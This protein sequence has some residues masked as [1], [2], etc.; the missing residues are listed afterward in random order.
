MLRPK[1]RGLFREKPDMS[2]MLESHELQ[3]RIL[4]E[5]RIIEHLKRNK[6]VVLGLN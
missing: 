2:A 6:G 5:D 3:E 4:G 1:T